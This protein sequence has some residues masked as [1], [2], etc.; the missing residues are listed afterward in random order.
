MNQECAYMRKASILRYGA[1]AVCSISVVPAIVAQ[2]SIRL[3]DPVNVRASASGTGFGSSAVTFNSA[4]LNLTCNASPIVAVLSSSADN[5]GNI[6]VDNNVQVSVT[7]GTAVTGPVNVCRGGTVDST[8]YGPSQN[9]FTS[10]YQGPAGNGQLTGQN[11]DTFVSTG[12]VTPI[13]IGSH[14]LPGMEQ[15]KIDLVD[16]G[17]FLASSTMY[18]NTNC[19]QN[20]VT[21]P[22]TITGNPI[23]QSN[24]TPAQLTQNFAF[25][26]TT[27]Q[28]VQFVYDLSIA[29]AAGTL[30]I[31]PAT[32][33][34]TDDLPYDPSNFQ[35]I[36]V[37]NTSFATSNCLI[38]SGELVN[39]LPACK[40]FT[41][42]CVVGTGSNASG[43]QCPI[44]SVPNEVF[45][46]VFDGPSFTLPDIATPN[47]PTFHQGVGFLMASEGWIGGPCTFDPAS[48]LQ[49]LPCPQNLLS[50]FSGPGIYTA[51]GK[52]SHPN[53]TF[54]PV[55]Q[56]PEDLTTVTVA[57][58]QTGGWINQSTPSIT[59]SSQPPV[60]AGTNLPGLATFVASPIQSITY[61]ISPASNVPSP[62]APASTD[63]VVENSVP[64]PSPANPSDPPAAPFSTG[65]QS[66]NQELA[67]GN[68]LV[69]YFAQD[70]AGTEELKFSQDG[71]GSWSTSYYTYPI[72]IDT[73]APVVATGPVLSPSAGSSGSYTVGQA[74]TATYSCTDERSGVT[75]C[76]SKT[77]S[78]GVSNTGAI[79]SPVDTSTTG[80]KTYVVT[81]VDAAG[82]QSSASVPYVVASSVDTAIKLTLGATTVTYPLGTNVTI[83][84]APTHGHVPTGLVRLYDGTAL[85]QTSQLQG[86]GA[87]YLYIQGLAVGAHQLSVVYAGDAFNPGGTSA[88]VTLTVKPVAVNLT[89]ACWNANFPYGAD[90]HCGVYA[91]SNAGA[92]QGVITYQYDGGSAVTLPLQGGSAQFVLTRP[93][94]G[95]HKVLINYAA[96]T[97]YAAAKP[98]NE[99]FLVTT[100]PVI[101]QLTPS[102]WYL[103]GGNLTLT[104]S[105][106]SWS[107]GPPNQIGT[108]AFYDGNRLIATVPVSASGTAS[109]TVAAST[110]SNGGHTIRASYSGGTNYS[111]G[112][113]SITIAVAR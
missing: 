53:S 110:L 14:L 108:V 70:C 3:F 79:T 105:I 97:N 93:P 17:T 8:P 5:T 51:T 81:A 96:Q 113:S 12:G 104:A 77:F 16:N 61:G 58:Q 100:A 25:N 22:A 107:A 46:D 99:S 39:G 23:P 47:G 11:P 30:S 67:D 65:P 48:G 4:T 111:A 35:S 80:S 56:V 24:P 6:L 88:P 52:T 86:N 60:L 101:I 74:V 33:P 71:N 78:G 32:I 28:Q 40:L 103:T 55:T 94:A 13:D 37:A 44:S 98:V 85:L 75:L 41:L 64:C 38:H 43:A 27:N 73:V 68:Y 18:L 7:S 109:T 89:A 84:V 90:Y 92:P 63:T 72:N 20:G 42:K 57:G 21:G 26:P 106:Q 91:S 62:G 66:L 36:L 31:T 1:I 10:S 19:S 69:H 112:T 76:G 50:T 9:C 102:S 54:I 59:L 29:Q 87:A 34:S 82:N 49:N 15:V 95:T 2:N 83:S 45:Q